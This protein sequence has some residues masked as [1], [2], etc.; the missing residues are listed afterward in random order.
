M[1]QYLTLSD[2]AGFNASFAGPDRHC[3]FGT[4]EGSVLR[5]QS[6]VG[7]LDAYPGI[8]DKAAALL[9]SPARTQAF[10]DGN[11]R[12]AWAAT[13]V[14]YAINGYQLSAEAGDAVGLTLDV[15]EGLIRRARH[16]RDLEGLGTAP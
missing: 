10:M 14:F 13:V 3:D 9:H 7:G 15:A 16:C 11:K 4:L 6:S 1:T 2:V 8:H 5:P 12:T